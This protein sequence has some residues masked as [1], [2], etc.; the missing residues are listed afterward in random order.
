MLLLSNF[1]HLTV[2]QLLQNIH[3]YSHSMPRW[4]D[5]PLQSIFEQYLNWNIDVLFTKWP[6]R[7]PDIVFVLEKIQENDPFF[8][9][10]SAADEIMFYNKLI[11]YGK[12]MNNKKKKSQ[13]NFT[14][15][16]FLIFL[17]CFKRVIVFN[18]R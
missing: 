14:P 5:K 7:F 10:G 17:V 18:C 2:V 13:N 11:H 9:P 4:Q 1:Q 8:R 12:K 16:F 6:E 3:N 15:I